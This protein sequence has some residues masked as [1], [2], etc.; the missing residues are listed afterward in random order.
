MSFQANL[1]SS[2][3]LIELPKPIRGNKEGRTL[4]GS[5]W[6]FHHSSQSRAA[7]ELCIA[8][9]GVSIELYDI[10]QPRKLLSFDLSP[11][12][13]FECA[14]V[15]Y[16]T[17]AGRNTI[18][19]R[20][21]YFATNQGPGL[22]RSITQLES[23]EFP[24]QGATLC[25][26]KH[27][28]LFVFPEAEECA[29][30]PAIFLGSFGLDPC[31]SS[32]CL[33]VV[34]E[35]ATIRCV[36][37]RQD[38]G[39][40]SPRKEYMARFSAKAG[41]V[42][43]EVVVEYVELV[44]ST[45]AIRGLLAGRPD[46]ANFLSYFIRSSNTEYGL[47]SVLVMATRPKYMTTFEN[48]V[49]TLTAI[50]VSPDHTCAHPA[51]ILFSISLP[52][53]HGTPRFFDWFKPENKA[54]LFRGVVP[55][56]I[57]SKVILYDITGSYPTVFRILDLGTQ[58][59]VSAL[60]LNNDVMMV[61]TKE[62]VRIYD[63][64]YQSILMSYSIHGG[65]SAGKLT[66][67][68]NDLK[69]FS[70]C[71]NQAFGISG[72]KI[73]VLEI[74]PESSTSERANS[75]MV[76][77][78]GLGIGP[79]E[80]RLE[81]QHPLPKGLARTE[82]NSYAPLLTHIKN[83]LDQC[84][85][86]RDYNEFERIVAAELKIPRSASI[87]VP[88]KQQLIK[89]APNDRDRTVSYPWCPDNLLVPQWE[90]PWL[91]HSG[92]SNDYIGP[93]HDMVLYLLATVFSWKPSK[94]DPTPHPILCLSM[95]YPN[96][97]H[98][99][100]ATENF[101]PSNIELAL[102]RYD[103]GLWARQRLAPRDFICAVVAADPN[104]ALLLKLIKSRQFTSIT[105]V[106]DAI[107]P[108]VLSLENPPRLWRSPSEL[109]QKS[110]PSPNPL[111]HEAADFPYEEVEEIKGAC[112]ADL[113]EELS[114]HQLPDIT[115]A[116]QTELRSSDI[117]AVIRV[118]RRE[119]T[120]N[121]WTLSYFDTP[122]YQALRHPPDRTKR[123][124]SLVMIAK[125]ISACIDAAGI[126]LLTEEDNWSLITSLSLEVSIALQGVKEAQDMAHLFT[127][128]SHYI[129]SCYE[130]D[131]VTPIAGTHN[132]GDFDNLSLLPLNFRRNPALTNTKV[133]AGGE[134]QDRTGRDQL[135]LLS[136][137]VGKYSHELIDI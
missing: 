23:E 17:R 86:Q 8:I 70:R 95:A 1:P 26:V 16:L 14:P 108:L 81:S 96:V 24:S 84:A 36:T 55:L 32:T 6:C 18:G 109:W 74:L 128:F 134:L 71:G 57:E 48:S 97:V 137:R 67:S 107:I 52:R 64:V 90:W 125:L 54:V 47:P 42:V 45:D 34:H 61:S 51:R 85:K 13:V 104:F 22:G 127:E 88:C 56:V 114:K 9:D 80:N 105:D 72:N 28:R 25:S 11:L 29:Q 102:Q 35:N 40:F 69:L 43:E 63:A 12:S 117:I 113:F 92:W 77:S 27:G 44:D 112:L 20:I 103:K 79:M 123:E 68:S 58:H 37:E 131:G 93:H 99:L 111:L 39:W 82:A 106:V 87:L 116:L 4:L 19:K 126:H 30:S 73:V 7:N 59:I 91:Q 62:Y 76:Y 2:H 60:M 135:R 110:I 10:T 118:L 78:L 120:A 46:Y 130:D 132:Q 31:V 21:V 49:R 66:K 98:W 129:K 100:V 41:S 136:M 3:E 124:E 122:K 65:E 94:T 119:L 33:L 101:T 121:Y 15:S 53:S 50:A 89:F 83:T 5:T 115:K 38:Q 133:A 75:R